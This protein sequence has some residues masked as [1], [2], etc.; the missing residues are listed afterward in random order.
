MQTNITGASGKVNYFQ[1]DLILTNHRD[2]ERPCHEAQRRLVEITKGLLDGVK[3]LNQR[4]PLVAVP[5]HGGAD[6]LPSTVCGG[7]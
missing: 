7:R 3:R 6:Q 1:A 2:A 4:L 5:S